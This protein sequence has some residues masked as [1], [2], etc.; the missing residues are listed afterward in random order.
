[1]IAA[2][3]LEASQPV[4]AAV[5]AAVVVVLAFAVQ[6]VV[7]TI[8]SYYFVLLYADLIVF[9]AYH[10]LIASLLSFFSTFLEIRHSGNSCGSCT[11]W[12]FAIFIFTCLPLL[13]LSKSFQ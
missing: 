13:C 3:V 8:S 9:A 10:T 12:G 5:V 4:V 11:L 6:T 7:A 1:M 2:A